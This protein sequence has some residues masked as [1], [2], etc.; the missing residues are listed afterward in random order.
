MTMKFDKFT[1]AFN[2]YIEK[3]NVNKVFFFVVFKQPESPKSK[4][5]T[6]YPIIGYE[7]INKDGVLLKLKFLG[8][9]DI[10]IDEL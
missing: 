7:S 5:S 6:F 8:C 2:I 9:M 3:K 1:F 10:Y 4:H